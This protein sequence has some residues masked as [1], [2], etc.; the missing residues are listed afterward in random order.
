[1]D[2]I[3]FFHMNQ[4]GDLLF[5]LPVLK[6]A[7]ENKNL[8]IS[9]I[10]KPALA[11][12]LISSGLIDSFIPKEKSL[13][14]QIKNIRKEK[15]N[16][17]V[18]FSESPS[19]LIAAYSSGIKQRVGFKSA[20]LNFLLTDKVS[21]TGVPSL[22][23][24]NNLGVSAGIKNIQKDYTGI[25][26]IPIQNIE[27]I[28]NWFRENNI[29]PE[30]A[31]VVSVGASKKRQD[32]CLPADKWIE[33][34]DSLKN[35]GYKCILSGAI[36]EKDDLEDISNMCTSKPKVFASEGG[37]MDSAALFKKC[38]LFTGI[39][40]GAMHLAAAVGT[41]CIAVFGYTD[42]LQVGPMPLD[43]HIIIKE[44][45]ISKIDPEVIIRNIYKTL[46]L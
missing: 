22:F 27:N 45:D 24:N 8:M 28:N 26:E 19:S 11:P 17:A 18:L 14:K 10:V 35:R 36:W 37:I 41:K 13:I 7:R 38:R 31:I 40:S 9:S 30:K 29:D 20:S 2:K 15:F 32:K 42:P 39:D 34:I 1:M 33:V 25:I 44:D 12:L 21:R 5:S 4:L 6:A 16:K 23:N 46:Q 3:V 43:E